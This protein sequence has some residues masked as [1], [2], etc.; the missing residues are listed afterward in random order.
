M[1]LAGDRGLEGLATFSAERRS[2]PDERA[3]VTPGIEALERTRAGLA[4]AVP[5]A[6]AR[7]DVRRNGDFPP[8]TDAAPAWLRNHWQVTSLGER[9]ATSFYYV[10]ANGKIE[11]TSLR[12]TSRNAAPISA[13]GKMDVEL[14]TFGLDRTGTIYVRWEGGDLERIVLGD[15]GPRSGVVFGL[16]TTK[17]GEAT[18]FAFGALGFALKPNRARRAMNF[19]PFGSRLAWG[20]SSVVETA[21]ALFSRPPVRGE[22]A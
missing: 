1:T 7:V 20:L 9:V 5:R 14:G 13:G 4:Y 19:L 21:Q 12:P 17:N 6:P 18:L 11:R 16:R 15:D 10:H 2:R 8:L 3:V 22:G